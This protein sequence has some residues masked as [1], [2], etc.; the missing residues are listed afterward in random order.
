MRKDMSFPERLL[1]SHL[2]AKQLDGI[3]VRRQAPLGPFIADFLCDE[4]RLV[5]ELDGESHDRSA[6]SDQRR[7]R[8]LN[9]QGYRV[10]RYNHDELLEDID[11]VLRD[12]A[13]HC[14]RDT[15]WW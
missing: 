12:I 7:T 15:R 8:F 6:D 2:K 9:E 10:V 3:K 4:H 1:W 5:I 13:R 14:G 11:S